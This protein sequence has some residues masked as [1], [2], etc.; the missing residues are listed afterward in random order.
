MREEL[1][2]RNN[3]GILLPVSSLPSKH[4]IGDFGKDSYFFIDWLSKHHYRYW[5]ILPLNPL[6]PGESPYMSTC[7]SAIDYRYI[8]LDFLVEEGLLKEVPTYRK[9]AEEVNF[10]GV[11]EFKKKYLYTAYLK[12]SKGPMNGLKKFKTKNPWVS[13]Y[14]TFETFKELN[15]FL[16]SPPRPP[17][18]DDSKRKY[19]Y[20]QSMT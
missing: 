17:S 1:V 2:M 16:F 5:Q 10:N 15:N 19:S 8:S 20:L 4:G 6:G 18:P 12:Y 14:A 7:S 9:S 13:K 11:K 3:L